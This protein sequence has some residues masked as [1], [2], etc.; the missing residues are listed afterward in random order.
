MNWRSKAGM[1]LAEILIGFLIIVSASVIFFQ[2]MHRFRKDTTFNSENYLASSLIEKVLEDCY[3]ESELNLHGMQAIGLADAA[4]KPYTVSTQ[5]TD[6]QTVFF[7][8]PPIT[9][10]SLPNLHHVLDDNFILSVKTEKKP[11]FYELT[12]GFEW[13]AESGKGR[14]FSS[15]R[16]LSFTGD[17]EVLTSFSMTTDKVKERLVKDLFNSTG[18]NLEVRVGS[19]GAQNLLVE[20]GHIYYPCLDWLNSADFKDRQQ[21]AKSLEVFSDAG[22][23]DYARCSRLYFEMARDLLHLMMSLKPHIAGVKTNISFIANIPLPT[24]FVAESRVHRAGVSYRQLRRIFFNCIL[25]VAERYEQQLKKAD[26]QRKQRQMIGR[27]FNI[28]RILHVNR[29]FSEEISSAEIV[30]RTDRFLGAMLNFF[31]DKDPSIYRMTDQ[32]RSFIAQNKLKNNFFMPRLIGELFKE[33][34]EFVVVTDLLPP[35]Q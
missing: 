20:V 22:S 31:R 15:T 5:V 11:G 30:A 6:K 27:L 33:I 28:N 1:S 2:T 13:K 35:V 25:K 32:E 7:S 19:I 17:K 14:A 16:I 9:V 24:R 26:S 10:A 3:Q 8:N 21:Q 12:A 23:D 29:E 34:D 18:S 4:G